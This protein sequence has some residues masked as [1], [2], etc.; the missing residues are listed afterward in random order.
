MLKD[1][2]EITLGWIWDHFG[3][4]LPSH[5]TDF[6]INLGWIWDHFGMTLPSHWNDFEITLGC[7][8]PYMCICACVYVHVY[9]CMSICACVYVHMCIFEI[10]LG[11]CLRITRALR[12]K[13]KCWKSVG[14][15]TIITSHE[16]SKSS[17]GKPDS[18]RRE[19]RSEINCSIE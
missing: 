14:F 19:S 2:F 3:M 12:K 6:E 7:L 1:D 9:M 13:R 5:W 8:Y 4:T 17:Q 11:V 10:T 18:P 16:D 15:R